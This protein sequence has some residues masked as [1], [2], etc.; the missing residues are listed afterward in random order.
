MPVKLVGVLSQ[1]KS[2]I[3]TD[4]RRLVAGLVT[5]LMVDVADSGLG[6]EDAKIGQEHK[7]ITSVCAAYPL[8]SA[9]FPFV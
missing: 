5:I 2:H 3:E 1:R 8:G 9:A 4:P 6:Q 7:K